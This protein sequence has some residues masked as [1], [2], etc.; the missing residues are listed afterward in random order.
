MYSPGVRLIVP[1]WVFVFCALLC[2]CGGGGG[3]GT[4]PSAP[5]G[6]STTPASITTTPPSSP[7]GVTSA[8]SAAASG[9]A[10]TATF[11]A[12]Q[13]GY[14][15]TVTLPGTASSGTAFML[16]AAS[17]PSG[18]PVPASSTR[19]PKA[20]GGT[21][22]TLA[23][24][25]F[26]TNAPLTFTTWPAFTFV[27][28]S[29]L[30]LQGAGLYLAFYSSADATA[31]WSTLAG[32]ATVSG[33]QVAFAPIRGPITF[34][35]GST[36]TFALIATGQVLISATPTPIATYTPTA[37]PSGLTAS[38]WTCPASGTGTFASFA[39]GTGS[40]EATHRYILR[41][42]TTFTGTST[43]AITYSRPGAL[44]NA[45][46]IATRERQLGLNLV[47]SYDSPRGNTVMHVVAVPSGS[48]AQTES[49]LRSQ[50]GVTSVGVTGERRYRTTSSAYYTNDPYFQGF[51]AN[52]E[53]LPYAETSAIPGQWDMHAIGLE[54][55]FGYSQAGA[56][57]AANP[58]ALGSS[59]IK[60]AIIDTGEDANHPELASK[61]AYQH[62]FITNDA[63][64]TP[65]P[66]STGNF[67]TDSD[68]HGTDVSGIA[69]AA[70]G[71][72]LGF[73][74]AGG[75][76][77]IYAYRIFPT[78]DDSCAGYN[79]DT[80]CSAD[81]GDIHLAIEDAIAQGVNVISMSLGGGGC[82]GNG[83]D[84]DPVEGA[85]V[86][87]AIRAN[88]IV[89]AASGNSGFGTA[90]VTAPGCDTGV[91]AAGA[92]S[93]DD[94]SQ[95]GTTG[96][97]TSSRAASATATSPVEYVAAYS[98]FGSPGEN[99]HSAGAW[100]IVAP[101]GDPGGNSDNDDLHWIENIWTSTPFVGFSGDQ[102]FSGECLSDFGS[103]SQADCRTLI[104]GT[105]MATPHV[106]GAAALILAVNPSY[107]S[108]AAMKALLCQTA[109]DISDSHQGCGRLNVYRAMATALN[110]PN[111]P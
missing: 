29:N 110:D 9:S 28:P 20:I 62:C 18:V 97:Y 59:S 93:L 6:V 40:T 96:S 65:G 84:T 72:S 51:A 89:V 67:S 74:G 14:G 56:S 90:A 76:T 1:A 42:P 44:A 21:L 31:G 92:T 106:A 34:S 91:I 52:F 98:Q 13:A 17:N 8:I 55:A 101:G 7:A 43:L 15:G 38:A 75:N 19:L 39:R 104:A 80:Q 58:L 82:T 109:D 107:Q 64:A 95:T 63:G 16:L 88:I 70:G 45:S 105:S 87:D 49:T 41:N 10:T 35:A 61:I 53:Q 47:H 68:G 79:G 86:A 77:V 103:T 81:T 25:S 33:A 36:Y 99:V 32:P 30:S 71:N 69:A 2:A 26:T 102:N 46:A 94:G 11:A 100:G 23:Y 4:T 48:L 22:T 37:S 3:G 83:N 78:P 111:L 108:P 73:A 50:P 85:A 54:H 66:Q 60:I 24:V 12:I 27:L 57:V 5:A